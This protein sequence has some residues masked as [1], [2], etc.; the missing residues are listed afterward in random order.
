MLRSL[1]VLSC[2]MLAA[3]VSQAVA[4]TP[5]DLKTQQLDMPADDAALRKELDDLMQS[6][7]FKDHWYCVRCIDG[8]THNCNNPIGGEVGRASCAA[9]NLPLCGGG[10]QVTFGHC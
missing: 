9:A 6:G 7:I 3:S 8:S 1:V 5:T 4:D 2:L 10:G